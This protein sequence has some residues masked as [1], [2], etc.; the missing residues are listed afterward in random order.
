MPKHQGVRIG[1]AERHQFNPGFQPEEPGKRL[2]ITTWT[3]ME[4]YD[5][6]GLRFGPWT[7]HVTPVWLRPK[8]T[9]ECTRTVQSISVFIFITFQCNMLKLEVSEIWCF[10]HKNAVLYVSVVVHSRAN[11]LAYNADF[12]VLILCFVCIFLSV[13][14]SLFTMAFLF[15]S[16]I[17][18]KKRWFSL[19]SW[20]FGVRELGFLRCSSQFWDYF[21]TA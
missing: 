6:W 13:F 12:D 1:R 19:W 7:S 18:G 9:S 4:H 11:R 5:Y 17:T 14:C 2:W 10:Y 15:S 21:Q 3:E 20:H 16:I 8:K